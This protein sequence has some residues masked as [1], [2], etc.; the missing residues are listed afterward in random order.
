VKQQQAEIERLKKDATRATAHDE[1]GGRKR[2]ETIRAHRKA[3]LHNL[4]KLID[5][6]GLTE[7]A[8]LNDCY[9]EIK[10]IKRFKCGKTY[11]MRCCFCDGE[12]QEVRPGKWQC[13]NPDCPTNRPDEGGGGT[14]IQRKPDFD[15]CPECGKY[16]GTL[17]GHVCS[18]HS[19]DNKETNQ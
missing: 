1:R 16:I 18:R 15:K 12:L 3:L 4:K 19:A 14:F 10:R 13:N 7:K 5:L 8:S 6:L 17:H 2:D 9:E 11:G